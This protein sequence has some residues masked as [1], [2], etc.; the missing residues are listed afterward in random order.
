M[1]EVFQPGEQAPCSGVYKVVHAF[2]HNTSHPVIALCGDTFPRC[3]ECSDE[4]RFEL[5]LSAV[6]M[7]VHPAF[8]AFTR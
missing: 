2:H 3:R 5:S 1:S 7:K 4:V 8:L 6:H